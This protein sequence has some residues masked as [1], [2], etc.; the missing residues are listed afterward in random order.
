MMGAERADNVIHFYENVSII[1]ALLLLS[2][3][4]AGRY[5]LGSAGRALSS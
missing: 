1:S 2:V 4:G 5:S 3:T